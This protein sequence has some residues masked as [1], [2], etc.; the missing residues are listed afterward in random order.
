MS[1]LIAKKVKTNV[2]LISVKLFSYATVQTSNL[3]HVYNNNYN[4]NY[5]FIVLICLQPFCKQHLCV[6]LL[7][8]LF[9]KFSQRQSSNHN[10]IVHTQLHT[11]LSE[12]LLTAVCFTLPFYSPT[13]RTFVFLPSREL[14]CDLI[15]VCV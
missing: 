1:L 11:R 3:Y 13:S 10:C 5:S 12:F 7:T 9:A 15:F 4:N 6:I 2:C 8:Q 14:Y